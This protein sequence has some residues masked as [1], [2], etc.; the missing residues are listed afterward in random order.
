[1]SDFYIRSELRV[2]ASLIIVFQCILH[3]R[4]AATQI[5]QR[6][7]AAYNIL[8]TLVCLSVVQG[9]LLQAFKG[10]GEKYKLFWPERREF[11]RMAAKF[12]ATVI[13]FAGVG[14]EDTLLML[15]DADDIKQIPIYGQRAEEDARKRAP[16]ARR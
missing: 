2:T 7:S 12:E 5:I 1:M 8:N 4:S 9:L 11:I 10:K 6:D 16:Q 13:P 15:A 3:V 14:V